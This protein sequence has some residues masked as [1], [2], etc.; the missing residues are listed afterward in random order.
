MAQRR[1]RGNLG[2]SNCTNFHQVYAR[3]ILSCVCVC[4]ICFFTHN[5]SQMTL[6]YGILARRTQNA[7]SGT[8][9]P[10]AG[11]VY[12]GFWLQASKSF[13]CS[14]QLKFFNFFKSSWT[15]VNST[16]IKFV[17]GQN[18]FPSE[19]KRIREGNLACPTNLVRP[20]PFLLQ[21]KGSGVGK[22][23]FLVASSTILSP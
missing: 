6:P 16:T 5:K 17:R 7:C 19:K 18:L 15:S 13:F 1:G 21:P 14:L 22:I 23:N 11:G 20:E 12:G 2:T 4:M 10:N 3:E 8:R 9:V